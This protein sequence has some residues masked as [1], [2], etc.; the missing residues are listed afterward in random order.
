VADRSA[1]PLVSTEWL[2]RH[3]DDPSVTIVEVSSEPAEEAAYTRGHV[4]GSHFA[5]WKQ[6]LW[7]DTDR[8]F[9]APAVIA[10]RLAM[11]GAG[12]GDTIALLGDPVQFST[13]AF[14]VLAMSGL[15]AR[16]V[17]VDGGREKWVAEGRPTTT[18]VPEPTPGH[19]D[20][21]PGDQSRR[22]G[23]DEVRAGLGDPRRLLIDVRSPEEYAGVRVSPPHFEFDYGAERTGRIPGARHLYYAD[24]FEEDGAYLSPEELRGRFR[25]L[26]IEGSDV[27]LYCRLSHR[28]TSVWFALEHLLGIDNVRVYDGSW[29]EWG[30]IVGFPIERNGPN[31]GDS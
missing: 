1:S 23:R 18:T 31:H 28:A 9:A 29:T 7:H 30:T 17:H 6:L 11:L 19:L 26:P 25:E 21:G 8:D 12:N 14:F 20:A 15:N 5:F 10:G 2:E 22:I 24:L 13:Y 3:L 27:V 4:P 16:V